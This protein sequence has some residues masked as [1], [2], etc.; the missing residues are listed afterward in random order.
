MNEQTRLM[1]TRPLALAIGLSVALELLN[2]LLFAV[3][4][5]GSD[6]LLAQF[7]WMVGIGGLGM[8]AVLGVFLDVIVV[9]RIEGKDAIRSTMLVSFLTLGVV[10]KLLTINMKLLSGNFVL[11]QWPGVY[12]IVGSMLAITGGFVLGW[13]LFSEKGNTYLAKHGL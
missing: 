13:L 2:F 5:G 3:L 12:F 1:F 7:V 4:P 6:Y 10:A 8:G 11:V 9:G